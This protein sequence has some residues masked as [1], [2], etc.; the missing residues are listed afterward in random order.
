[1]SESLGKM[2]CPRGYADANLT[3]FQVWEVIGC[4]EPL[5]YWYLS[6]RHIFRPNSQT[7]MCMFCVHKRN[8]SLRHFFYTYKTCYQLKLYSS[9]FCL[10]VNLQYCICAA[11]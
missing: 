8:V 9:S 4:I 2:K 6:L 1:M 3:D 10:S 5:R 7:F 11:H